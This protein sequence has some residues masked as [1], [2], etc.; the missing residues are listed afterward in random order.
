MLSAAVILTFF[1]QER[2]VA[3]GDLVTMLLKAAVSD[4]LVA[5]SLQTL[6]VEHQAPHQYGQKDKTVIRD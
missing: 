4:S 2:T 5:D 6:P 3:Q 1:T